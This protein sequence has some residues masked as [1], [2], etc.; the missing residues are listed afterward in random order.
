MRILV[1]AVPAAGHFNPLTGPAVRLKE[2]G[3]EVWWYAG[4]AYAAKVE[5]L[6][7]EVLPYRHA[8]EVT[9]DNLNAL[10]PERQKLRG[11]KLV[12]FDGDTMFARPIQGYFHDIRDAHAELPFDALLAD[13]A[14]YASYLVAKRLHLP[15]YTL[16]SIAAPTFRGKN[17][18]TPFF[19]LRPPRTP[20]GHVI[21]RVTRAMVLSSSRKGLDTI[22]RYLAEEGLPSIGAED[23]F[24][25]TQEPDVARR[26]FN[27][28]LPELDFPD[29]YT[30]PNTQWVGALPPHSVRSTQMLDP[31]ITERSGRVVIVSQG[32]VDNHDPSKLMIPT[33]QS[34]SDSDRL[35][36]VATGGVGTAELRAKYASNT[37]LIEDF[38][39]F[40][41]VFPHTELYVTNGGLGGVLQALTHGVPLLVAG[42]RE[43]KGD[44]NARLA[45]RGLAVDLHTERPSARKIARGARQVLGDADMRTRVA[46]TARALAAYDSVD[47][48]T[49]TVLDE[50][51]M[52]RGQ[53]GAQNGRHEQD[54]RRPST[55][56]GRTGAPR[57]R[58]G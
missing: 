18:V 41:Q 49:R 14:F 39:D 16:G 42:M 10:F 38:V 52:L 44:I 21:N 37:V 3:H 8:R 17:P 5:Q 32:T 50:Q 33:I 31:R 19:G 11:P 47:L 56:A 57:R 2:L 24:D 7:L 28:G 25:C 46:A 9:A 4:P 53:F 48:I 36:V 27:V 51:Q 6:G 43:G 1:A 40:D 26:V 22:N 55:R 13:G 12:E 58:R 29:T 20:V 23:Y 35:L 15:V 34:F 45:F 54:V 30:P